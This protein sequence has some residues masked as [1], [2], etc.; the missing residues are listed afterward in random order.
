MQQVRK[1]P[2]TR[3]GNCCGEGRIRPKP[4]PGRVPIRR[5]SMHRSACVTLDMCQRKHA[6]ILFLHAQYISYEA[7]PNF[8]VQTNIESDNWS[9]AG[10][11]ALHRACFYKLLVSATLLL[12]ATSDADAVDEVRSQLLLRIM[13]LQYKLHMYPFSSVFVLTKNC[14]DAGWK[15]GASRR[16]SLRLQRD[17]FSPRAHRPPRCQ[18]S[19]ATNQVDATARCASHPPSLSAYLRLP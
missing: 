13:A 15:D 5:R 18:R 1:A 11:T 16:S 9:F 17:R 2:P 7:S 4:V 10:S 12:S 6:W 3:S 8:R 19:V 14:N